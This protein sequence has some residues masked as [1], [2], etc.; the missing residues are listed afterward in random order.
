MQLLQMI[1]LKFYPQLKS[2]YLVGEFRS[3]VKNLKKLNLFELIKDIYKSKEIKILWNLFGYACCRTS[4]EGGFYKGLGII[5]GKVK[6]IKKEG[7]LRN[8]T[9][10][11]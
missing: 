2:F 5:P 8:P 7:N 10:W 4:E 11:I 9:Y 6:E 3:A 1:M